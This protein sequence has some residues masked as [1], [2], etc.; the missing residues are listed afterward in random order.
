MHIK[1]LVSDAYGH[2]KDSGFHDDTPTDFD[3]ARGREWLGS[4]LALIHSEVSEAL[5]E[6]RS[7]DGALDYYYQESG[8]PEGVASELA[9][10]VIRVADLAGAAGINLDAAITEKLA[11]NRSRPRRH[12]KHF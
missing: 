1:D 9:D 7:N 5:E 8:K 6:A 4:K 12:G 2:A 3:S 11:Y 10:V